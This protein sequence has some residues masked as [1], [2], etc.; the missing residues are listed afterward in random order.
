[1]IVTATQFLRPN[2]RQQE[3]TSEISDQYLQAYEALIQAGL[4]ITMEVLMTGLV[5]IC[6]EHEEYGDLD[7]EVV[8]NGP[9]VTT[10]V[11]SMLGRIDDSLLRLSRMERGL[12]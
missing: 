8:P 3:V 7:I 5:S 12:E 11:E 9:E 4:R 10:A 6:V 1:M 2:G